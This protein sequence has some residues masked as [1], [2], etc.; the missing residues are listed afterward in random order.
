MKY[1]VTG[2]AGH[3]GEAL[4]RTL[5]AG[6]AVGL[7]AR[8]SPYTQVVGSITERDVVAEAMR[9]VDAVLHAATLHKP[10][11]E[12]H[13]RQDFV[14][15]NVIG[16]LNILEEAAAQGVGRV[17]FTSTTSAFGAALSAPPG[18]PASWIDED[19]RPIPKNIYGATKTAAEDLCAL[20]HR[21][22]GLP[23]V[24]LRTSRF[25]PEEDD[26][27]EAR[28][29]FSDENLKANEFLYRRL[30]VADAVSAHLLAAEQ[31]EAIGFDRFIVSATTPFTRDDAPLLGRDGSAALAARFPDQ[32][33]I[34]AARDWRAPERFDRVYDNSR[35][36]AALGWRPEFDFARILEQAAAGEQIGSDLARAVGAKGYHGGAGRYPFL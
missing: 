27:A 34:Y 15:V 3:L 11:V 36:R 2:S 13:T 9:G 24:V 31:A 8:P 35:A 20:F 17:V 6:D 19:V 29:A 4:M 10:H 30:D 33:A 28:A 26:S 25:F 22:H 18:A 14:N 23:V 12:T 5:P 16:T 1:L 21:L 7:D 32:P